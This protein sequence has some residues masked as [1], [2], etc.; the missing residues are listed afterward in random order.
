MTWISRGMPF[1]GGVDNAAHLRW[2]LGVKSTKI[3]FGG[4]NKHCQLF[5]PNAMNIKT[6]VLSKLLH[7]FQP[8][9]VQ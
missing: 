9:F 4:V 1:R 3:H 5:K 2:P 7:R 8:N 6:F